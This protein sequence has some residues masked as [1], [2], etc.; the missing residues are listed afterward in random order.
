MLST[1]VS[2]ALS[3][4]KLN[5]FGKTLAI[6]QLADD[7]TLFLQNKDQIP[8]A[9]LLDISVISAVIYFNIIQYNTANSLYSK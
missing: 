4:K 7:T 5:I 1:L 8:L 9:T 3:V 2:H 6:S